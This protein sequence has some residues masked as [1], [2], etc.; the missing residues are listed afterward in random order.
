MKTKM[1]LSVAVLVLALLG[2]CQSTEKK[3][4][5]NLAG[6]GPMPV[7]VMPLQKTTHQEAIPV[8][9]QFTTNDEAV[10]SFK[11]GGV[12]QNILVK[13]GESVRKGQLLATLNLTEIE[14]QVTQAKLG[15]EKAQRDFNRAENLFRDS[16]YTLEQFQN[17]KTALELAQ[18]Q[19]KAA[20]FNQSYSNIR[21]VEN[22]IVLKKF[23]NPGQVVQPGDPILQTNGA[24]TSNWILKVGVSD[25]EWARIKLQ[26]KATIETDAA[27]Q[28]KLTGFVSNKSAGADPA[29]GS[30]EIEIKLATKEQQKVAAGMFGKAIIYPSTPAPLWQIPYEALLDGNADKGF[31]F[32]TTDNKTARKIPVTIAAIQNQNLLISQGLENVPSLIVSGSAYLTDNT[33]IAIIK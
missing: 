10:L 2:A 7:K 13:E 32:V 15:L 33:P 26:D 24:G 11:T 19:L 28:G 1:Y 20:Q 12:V 6:N 17:T 30:F 22:G 16:V 31:V 5:V 23:V 4:K 21:A 29:T 8:S 14:A 27:P 25:K 3:E 18:Q 9:G